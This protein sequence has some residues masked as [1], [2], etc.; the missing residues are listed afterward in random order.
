MVKKFQLEVLQTETA[1]V[2]GALTILETMAYI[3]AGN[4]D[5]NVKH[6]ELLRSNIEVAKELV[7]RYRLYLNSIKL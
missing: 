3:M 4:I 7:D 1:T 2:K 5:Y 6:S